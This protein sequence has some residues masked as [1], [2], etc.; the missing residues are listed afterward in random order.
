M[1]KKRNPFLAFLLATV[2]G[3]GQL[4]NGQVKKASI[5]LLI[6]YIAIFFLF[7]TQIFMSVIGLYSLI[8]FSVG[9]IIY[10]LIDAVIVAKKQKE[11]ELKNY[12][13]WYFYVLFIVFIYSSH[14][15]IE[16]TSTTTLRSFNIPTG[17][18]EPTIP[19]GDRI[20]AQTGF[21]K[22]HD[23]VRNDLIIFH[24]PA[25]LDKPIDE[26]TYYVSRCVAIPGDTFS[27]INKQVHI[28]GQPSTIA[29]QLKYKFKCYT[30]N[31]LSER[32]KNER[33][34]KEYRI[35]S[36]D[37]FGNDMLTRNGKKLYLIDIS[38]DHVE[39]LR[40]ANIFD[41]II[42]FKLEELDQSTMLF[43]YA[44]QYKQW[45]CD[46]YGKIWIPKA[47]VTIQLTPYLIETYGQT[48]SQYEGHTKVESKDGQLF[49]DDK[50]V[51]S[52]TFK[53]NYYFTMGDN[54]HSS[55]D[56]R[57]W[58]FV[59]EDHLVGK[60]WLVFYSYDPDLSYPDNFLKDR[61][62]MPIK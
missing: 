47:G 8:L 43:P 31:L 14:F 26:K 57:Y 3:L 50:L 45:T 12:N 56:G 11:Y 25:E 4:Y 35:H 38:T 29:S 28:N 6:D 61:F 22:N 27:I 37:F 48:I 13:K 17:S 19:V 2:P 24:Y 44:H 52:Y 62:F 33:L 32:L 53:Q 40:S 51:S 60:A 21:Y 30:N 54:R 41:S 36:Y 18:M 10:R 58:G 15:I 20:I 1:I 9:M 23:M 55:A 46:D 5:V 7:Y 16:K 49:I 39:K 59:P 42:D 34:K